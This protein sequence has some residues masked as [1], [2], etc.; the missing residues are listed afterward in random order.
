MEQERKDELNNAVNEV[1]RYN[2]WRR[3]RTNCFSRRADYPKELGESLDIVC[4][5]VLDYLE[6]Q[7]DF[8]RVVQERNELKRKAAEF[9]KTGL[10]VIKERNQLKSTTSRR[11]WRH[12]GFRTNGRRNGNRKERLE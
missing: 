11:C 3:G 9:A 10:A 2:L 12:S 4:G 7:K 6:L 1:A 5:G 8:D